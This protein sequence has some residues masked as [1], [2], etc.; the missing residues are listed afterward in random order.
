V[1]LLGIASTAKLIISYHVGEARDEA[2][3]DVFIRDLR[4]RLA[5]I[6]LLNTDGLSAYEPAVARWFGTRAQLP[7]G[8]RSARDRLL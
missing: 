7:Q 8:L 2:N 1:A 5:T 3:C 6:P 4:G